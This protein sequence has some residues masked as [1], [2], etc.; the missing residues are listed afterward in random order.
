MKS[1]AK[2]MSALIN[3]VLDFARGRLGTGIGVEF[4]DADHIDE[5]LMAVVRE[6]EDAQPER[7]IIADIDVHRRVR[8]DLGRVQQLASNLLGNA[9][10][11]GAAD[12]PVRICA[13]VEGAEFVLS[14]VNAGEPIAPENIDKIFAP[15]WRRSTAANREG[16]GLG[17]HIC[18]QIVRAHGGRLSVTSSREHGTEFTARLPLTESRALDVAAPLNAMR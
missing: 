4:T 16:L 18:S 9:L 3:D 2:R 11:H 1:N 8:C 15:F 13:R 12:R 10:S 5:G 14:V 17:L 7:T 6:L